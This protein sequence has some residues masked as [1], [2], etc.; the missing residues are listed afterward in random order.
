MGGNSTKIKEEGESKDDY[1]VR[2]RRL[3]PTR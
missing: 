2:C 3:R 1:A